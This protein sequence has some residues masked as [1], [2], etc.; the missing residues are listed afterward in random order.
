M[1]KL[2][3]VILVLSTVF[4]FTAMAKP[5]SV[6]I[7]APAEDTV[8]FSITDGTLSAQYT[9]LDLTCGSRF[10]L[11]THTYAAKINGEHT[12]AEWTGVLLT[13]LLLDAQ[14]QGVRL[15]DTCTLSAVASDGFESFFTVAD[16]LDETMYYMVAVDPVHTAD[17]DTDYGDSFVRI[18]RD[19]PM[20]NQSTM[21]CILSLTVLDADR[22]P[23]P[24]AQ[25]TA[26]Q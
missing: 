2:I 8:I 5:I 3:S 13:D 23:L 6:A 18:M 20:S 19:L 24:P 15:N 26:E 9:W 16:V 21:R 25:E 11:H 12:T 17:G 1:K 14:T 10:P 7:D 22:Q 4:L